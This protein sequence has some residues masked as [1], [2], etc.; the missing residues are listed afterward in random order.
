MKKLLFI[1]ALFA[2]THIVAQQIVIFDKGD[3]C[4]SNSDT[5]RSCRPSDPDKAAFLASFK[6]RMATNIPLND[7]FNFDTPPIAW[8]KKVND[9]KLGRAAYDT[10][11]TKGFIA[12]VWL[13]NLLPKHE[14]ILTLN[15]RPDLAGNNLLTESVPG[16]PV[17]KYYDF[18]IIRTDE[19][20]DYHSKLGVYLKPGKYQVRFYVK[21]NDDK[22]II[23]YHD[24]F[25]F[26][27][28]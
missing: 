26:T 6:T 8:G 1:A 11:F 15:G 24:Y 7:N 13:N 3:I 27:V 20:G 9:F 5:S 28:N 22:L 14:Y 2:A 18:L 17:E 25:K 21:D 23:L 10:S 19:K 12:E 16:N 4:Y